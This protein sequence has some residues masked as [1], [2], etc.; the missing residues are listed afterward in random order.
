M[1]TR[2]DAPCF[3]L[4]SL[5]FLTCTMHTLMHTLHIILRGKNV[6]VWFSYVACAEYSTR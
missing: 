5:P 3:Y 2:R 6:L 1:G 4:P